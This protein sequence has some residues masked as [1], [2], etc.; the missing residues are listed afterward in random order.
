MVDFRGAKGWISR[1]QGVGLGRTK[2]RLAEAMK[3]TSEG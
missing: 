2:V 3:K 1:D